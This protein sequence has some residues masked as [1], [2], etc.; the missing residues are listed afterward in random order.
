MMRT[1]AIG[2][3]I[4]LVIVLMAATLLV[5]TGP[6]LN[7]A[8]PSSSSSES[9]SSESF[10][11]S[12]SAPATVS[13]A[14][15]AA[16]TAAITT[17]LADGGEEI[18][19]LTYCDIAN[20]PEQM[21]VYFPPGVEPNDNTSASSSY[22][23]V[24][25]VNGG[26][27]II[28]TKTINWFNMFSLLSSNGFIV[29]SI[30][31]AM[32][33]P[34]PSFPANIEDVACAVRFLRFDSAR[35]RVDPN[36]IGLLGDSSGGH[37]VALEALSSANNRTFDVGPYTQY[38]SRVQAVVDA[39]G[40][41]NLTDPSFLGTTIDSQIRLRQVNLTQLVFGGSMANLARASPVNYVAAAS[42]NNRSSTAAPPFLI[43][44]GMN[45]TIVPMIQSVQLYDALTSHSDSA[46]L[47][48]VQ[49]CDHEFRQFS[50]N[51]PMS[52]TI[53]QIQQDILNFY[54]ANLMKS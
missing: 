37:L 26:A 38:S 51:S 6:M 11:T 49:N 9:L 27:W 24:L 10:A 28:S 39:F 14:A 13:S 18:I 33:P 45:D 36:R 3:A 20:Q 1:T 44:Q 35:L 21:D 25:Y 5:A 4:T 40:P 34:S 52:P 46:D 2:L 17:S 29:A 47:V 7:R 15:A 53:P 43:F 54:D 41:A 22:P 23:A 31:Y 16:A 48:L 19:N 42:S 8:Q 50:P 32:P 12:S 30:D